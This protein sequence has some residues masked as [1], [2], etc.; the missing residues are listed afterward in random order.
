MEN[1]HAM[2]LTVA[3]SVY[4]LWLIIISNIK[5]KNIIQNKQDA[6]EIQILYNNQIESDNKL[7]S[8]PHIFKAGRVNVFKMTFLPKFLDQFF[9]CY[10]N[11]ATPFLLE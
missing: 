11:F 7:S 6:L 8:I 10:T 5:G 3:V 1:F 4:S 2:T 9:G